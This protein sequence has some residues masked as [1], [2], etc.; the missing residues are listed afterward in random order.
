MADVEIPPVPECRWRLD[1]DKPGR[2]IIDVTSLGFKVPA[3]DDDA[4][5]HTSW[6]KRR[7]DR[8]AAGLTLLGPEDRE[9]TPECWC[10]NALRRASAAKRREEVPYCPEHGTPEKRGLM[11]GT[12]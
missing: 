1:C 2:N 6:A 12:R 8:E 7:A 9:P 5:W 4:E 10:P 3:C 11:E